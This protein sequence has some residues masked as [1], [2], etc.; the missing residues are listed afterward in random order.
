MT[1]V[2]GESGL[3]GCLAGWASGRKRGDFI[4]VYLKLENLIVHIG[5]L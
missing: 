4:G 3:K 1:V 2:V 5:R